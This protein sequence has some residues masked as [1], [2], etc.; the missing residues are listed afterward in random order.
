MQQKFQKSLPIEKDKLTFTLNC[1]RDLDDI[2]V[3]T[4]LT[5]PIHITSEYIQTLDTSSKTI[6]KYGI[7][8]KATIPQKKIF[9]KVEDNYLFV[10]KS[11]DKKQLVTTYSRSAE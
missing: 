10:F 8:C 11:K 6:D 4:T 7:E 3:S 1:N 5:V 2:S 9:Y